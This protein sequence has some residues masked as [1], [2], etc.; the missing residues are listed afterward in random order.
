V[1]F[2]S[3]WCFPGVGEMSFSTEHILCQFFHHCAEGITPGQSL[4][5]K[6]NWKQM[7]LGFYF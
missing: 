4:A 3:L 1:L 2:F 6:I 7:F 5:S